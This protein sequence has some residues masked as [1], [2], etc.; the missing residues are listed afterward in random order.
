MLDA[1]QEEAIKVASHE[2]TWTYPSRAL[3]FMCHT[4]NAG[5]VLGPKTRQLNGDFIDRAGNKEN[6]LRVWNRP[7]MFDPPLD[8][9]AIASYSKTSAIDDPA[10]PLED[11]VRSYLDGNCSQCHRPG[12][13]GAG[14]DA[15]FEI[16]LASQGILGGGIRNT[17]G[18]DGAKVVA[19]GDVA[20]S[21]LHHR[22][23]STSVAEQMPPLTRNVPD[24]VTL[25]VLSQ[26]IRGLDPD[27][28]GR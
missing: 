8:E 28:A 21:I 14:W 1:G 2:Q 18:I 6:Q 16:P 25:E 10:A 24:A 23:A 13:T 17:L 20:R 19:A 7:K 11:R 22:M 12:G 15:R 26:W 4:P 27:K 3:C 5:F 9:K